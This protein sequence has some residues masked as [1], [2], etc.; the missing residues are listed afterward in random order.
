[1]ALFRSPLEKTEFVKP[2]IVTSLVFLLILG[3]TVISAGGDKKEV[4][5]IS[6]HIVKQMLQNSDVVIIDVRKHR[7]WWRSNKKILKAVRENP[8]NVDQWANQ[9]PKDKSLIFY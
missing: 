4:P 9:Y 2:S 5:G 6:V 1:M 3:F 8:S 7:N